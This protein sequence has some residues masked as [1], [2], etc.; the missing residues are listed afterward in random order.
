MVNIRKKAFAGI[1]LS[2]LFLGT[3]VVGYIGHFDKCVE[4]T[5]ISNAVTG[6]VLLLGGVYALI[7]KREI[8]QFLY[9]DCAVLMSSVIAACL[10]FAPPML[11]VGLAFIPHLLNPMVMFVYYLRF[12][13]GRQGKLRHVPTVLVLPTVYYVF[14]IL[15]GI[16]GPRAVYPQFD[17]NILSALDLTFVGA[18]ALVGLFA[19]GVILFKL[20]IR[21]HNSAQKRKL[22]GA[23]QNAS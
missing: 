13:D 3:A 10:L 7:F 2:F 8:P 5:F 22:R 11:V 20:N 4:M 12:C 9:L 18:A 19:V 16:M 6:T 21:L 23:D 1:V 17:P 14:M 15:Y